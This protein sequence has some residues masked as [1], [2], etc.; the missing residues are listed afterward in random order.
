MRYS[1]GRGGP[2]YFQWGRGLIACITLVV[3]V[4]RDVT[5]RGGVA[6]EQDCGAG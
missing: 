2:W 5:D 1:S 6:C 3:E 4:G